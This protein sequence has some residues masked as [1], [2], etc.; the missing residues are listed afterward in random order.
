M[1]T[2]DEKSPEKTTPCKMCNDTKRVS[3][4]DVWAISRAAKEAGGAM[5][6]FD[7]FDAFPMVPGGAPCPRCVGAI[8]NDAA[9]DEMNEKWG[10][11]YAE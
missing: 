10:N 5:P 3:V 11:P 4:L 6:S 8:E 1:N 9:I 2:R 7:S